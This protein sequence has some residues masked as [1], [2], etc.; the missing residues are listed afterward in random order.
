MR[1]QQDL[2]QDIRTFTDYDNTDFLYGRDSRIPW[3]EGYSFPPKEEMSDE[4]R[5]FIKERFERV[6]DRCAA[7]LEIGVNNELLNG[8][9]S[10]YVFLEN[11]LDSTIYLGIDQIDKSYL[12]NPSKNIFTLQVDSTRYSENVRLI[13]EMG[14]TKFDFIFIDGN[15]SINNVLADWE[16]TELLDDN[17][18]VGFHDVSQHPG[19]YHFVKYLDRNKWV[20][21]ENL[22][23][24][25]NG[26]AFV[27]KK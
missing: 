23:P 11:K 13:R 5:N 12:D 15:H 2:T 27:W 9:S 21:E 26:I 20:V 24:Y 22:C 7:I 8:K 10:T 16:Y 19:P 4:N 6:K 3:P 14:I 18:I 1:W 25:D 17:G